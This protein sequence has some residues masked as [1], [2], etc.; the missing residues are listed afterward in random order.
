MSWGLD[1]KKRGPLA[2]SEGFATP[3]LG[4]LRGLERGKGPWAAIQAG[5]LGLALEEAY[6]LLPGLSCG[7]APAGG[8]RAQ[9]LRGAGLRKHR[10]GD[11]VVPRARGATPVKHA[12]QDDGLYLEV[13]QARNKF[14]LIEQ[15][16]Y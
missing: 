6:P 9:R 14:L 13:Q 16:R 7:W 15:M 3:F 10:T 1:V 11:R 4:G 2:G 8:A 5:G 12:P